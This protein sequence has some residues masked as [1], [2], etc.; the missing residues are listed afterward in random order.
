M[1]SCVIQL[2]DCSALSTSGISLTCNRCDMRNDDSS[3]SPEIPTRQHLSS[4][5]H[6][7]VSSPE[8]SNH[9]RERIDRLQAYANPSSPTSQ[10]NTRSPPPDLFLASTSTVHIENTTLKELL[11]QET[12]RVN[13]LEELLGEQEHKHTL[14]V[15]ELSKKIIQMMDPMALSVE[16][17]NKGSGQA[18]ELELPVPTALP[19]PPE[20]PVQKTRKNFTRLNSSSR[21]EHE[22]VRDTSATD[23]PTLPLTL[24]KPAAT[25]I[26]VAPTA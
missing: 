10:Q 9:R 14:K 26:S 7:R 23:S 4:V 6:T 12:A 24:A 5:E 13:A 15:A 11:K 16:T 3:F 17:G 8:H 21:G 18:Q 22:I 2:A 20:R 25:E 1:K 19:P